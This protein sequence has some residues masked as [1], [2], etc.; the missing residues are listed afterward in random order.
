MATDITKDHILR[1]I[2]GDNDWCPVAL[3][4]KTQF[5]HAEVSERE[6][7]TSNASWG[8][9]NISEMDYSLEKWIFD[10]DSGEREMQPITIDLVNGIWKIVEEKQ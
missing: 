9:K 5:A 7:E 10:F 3:G 4:L 1:G 2:P 8:D 6:I